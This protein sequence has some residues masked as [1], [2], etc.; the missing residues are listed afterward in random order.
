M[1]GYVSR[2]LKLAVQ[3]STLSSCRMQSVAARLTHS[4]RIDPLI[5]SLSELDEYLKVQ[6]L[7]NMIN[8][9]LR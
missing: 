1:T 8:R 2:L 7:R 4:A 5:S 6:Y 3:V 9:N